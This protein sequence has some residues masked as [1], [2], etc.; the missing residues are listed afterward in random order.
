M[1]NKLDVPH[2]WS[3][4]TERAV[5]KQ[6]ELAKGV[7]STDQSFEEMRIAYNKERFPPIREKLKSDSTDRWKQRHFLV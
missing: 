5:A 4:E 7:Y 1:V 3:E 2:L 6:E